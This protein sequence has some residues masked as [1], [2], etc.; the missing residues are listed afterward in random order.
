MRNTVVARR[1]ARALFEL[2]TEREILESIS[3]EIISFEQNLQIN[4]GFRHFLHSQ[5]ISKKEKR[6]KLEKVLQDRISNVLFNFLLVLL[7]KNRE[8]IFLDIARD[9]RLLVDKHYNRTSASAVSAVPLDKKSIAK[10]KST[11][12]DAFGIDVRIDNRVDESILGGIIVNVDGRLLDGSLRSQLSK[13]K[14][15][16]I[17]NTGSNSH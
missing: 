11:L 1:Y 10:L 8:S 4:P 2:A 14:W 7:K 9:F 6:A 13:L 3:N 16:L 15:Q 5:D 17:Q 12:D